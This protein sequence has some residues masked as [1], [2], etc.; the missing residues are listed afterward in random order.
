MQDVIKIIAQG[1]FCRWD[2]ANPTHGPNHWIR[3]TNV[4]WPFGRKT[5]T[6]ESIWKGQREHL[7]K[8]WRKNKTRGTLNWEAQWTLSTLRTFLERQKSHD[9]QGQDVTKI[10][11]MLRIWNYAERWRNWHELK[12]QWDSDKTRNPRNS[13]KLSQS[14]FVDCSLLSVL[15]SKL[16]QENCD[17]WWRRWGDKI[18]K[19]GG[20]QVWKQTGT[21]DGL[22]FWPGCKMATRKMNPPGIG[23]AQRLVWQNWQTTLN[24]D[25]YFGKLLNW[26]TDHSRRPLLR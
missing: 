11:S 5:E 9:D 15:I 8:T 3:W 12:K 26:W 25:S 14:N 20:G 7:E 13:R 23:V 22:A 4:E 18:V 16:S 6:G 17:I 1:Q 10:N 24:R 21:S 19:E 2:S